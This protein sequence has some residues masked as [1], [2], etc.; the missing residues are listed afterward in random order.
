MITA[1]KA[2]DSHDVPGTITWEAFLHLR[3]RI[4]L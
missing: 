4:Q 1:A 3:E 2:E